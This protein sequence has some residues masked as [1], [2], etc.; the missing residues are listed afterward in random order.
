MVT[1]YM[2]WDRDAEREGRHQRLLGREVYCGD[3]F[4]ILIGNNWL[5][6]RYGMF[7]NSKCGYLILGDNFYLDPPP[8]FIARWGE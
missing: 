6:V 4:Q 1:S 5:W 7:C 8:Q 3:C 2:V